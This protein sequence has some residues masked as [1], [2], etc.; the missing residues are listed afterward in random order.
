VREDAVQLLAVIQDSL[1]I[2]E[3]HRG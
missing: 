3:Q 1:P 2:L